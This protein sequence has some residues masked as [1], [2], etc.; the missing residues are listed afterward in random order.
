MC[1]YNCD[2]K[3]ALKQG[4][5]KEESRASG[6]VERKSGLG[7]HGRQVGHR[8][9]FKLLPASAKAAREVWSQD[10]IGFLETGISGLWKFGD[11]P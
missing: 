9:W 8:C 2:T 10:K 11:Y 6:L 5:E 7:K 1:I 3:F 4:H